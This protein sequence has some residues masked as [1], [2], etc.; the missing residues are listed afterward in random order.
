[1]IIVGGGNSAICAAMAAAE[2]GARVLLL[3]AAPEHMRGGNTPRTRNIHCAH[4]K[5]DAFS[6]G[7]YP[8][9]EYMAHLIAVTGGPANID[10]AKSP[11]RRQ[12]NYLNGFFAILVSGQHRLSCICREMGSTRW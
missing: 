11:F 1:V 2:N 9:K 12:T 7:P 6:F 10:L 5:A 3:E 8:D 4:S